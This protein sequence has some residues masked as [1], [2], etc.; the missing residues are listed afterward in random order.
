[1]GSSKK[2]GERENFQKIHS[3]G[4]KDPASARAG[5]KGDASRITND[6]S[7]TTGREEVEG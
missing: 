2:K 3:F 7:R 4:Q 5:R 1:M 6:L